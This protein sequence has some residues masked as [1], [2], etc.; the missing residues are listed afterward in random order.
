M[1]IQRAGGDGVR[2]QPLLVAPTGCLSLAPRASARCYEHRSPRE[3]RRCRVGRSGAGGWAEAARDPLAVR[4]LE[5]DEL[6]R[7]DPGGLVDVLGRCRRV[8]VH[9]LAPQLT[10]PLQPAPTL[11][12]DHPDRGERLEIEAR[13]GGVTT[14]ANLGQLRSERDQFHDLVVELIHAPFDGLDA[15]E[16]DRVLR[17]IRSP[18]RVKVEV[19]TNSA[20]ATRSAIRCRRT[21]DTRSRIFAFSARARSGS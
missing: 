12:T 4:V 20:I 10:Q 17:V 18:E 11:G 2:Q 1:G 5:R 15:V 7:D 19:L 6:A 8:H 21:S 16:L 3:Y 9:A 14:P 13:V